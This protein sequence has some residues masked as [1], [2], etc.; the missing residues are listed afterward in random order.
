MVDP[1]GFVRDMYEKKLKTAG[2][3]FRGLECAEDDFLE[4]VVKWKPALI[5][6]DV[7]LR[8]EVGK[9]SV[10]MPNGYV[11]TQKLKNDPRT[12]HIP[13]FFLTN[14]G[15]KVDVDRGMAVGAVGYIIKVNTLPDDV[16]KVFSEY[17]KSHKKAI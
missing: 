17:L 16:V 11:I 5:S 10:G 12:T 8:K 2:F 3:E 13:V 7:L 14:Q 4:K 15:Q 6:M 9:K 1:N